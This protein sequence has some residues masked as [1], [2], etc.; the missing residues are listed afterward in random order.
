MI[1]KVVDASCRLSEPGIVEAWQ[2]N[3]HE[4]GTR[5]YGN[6][7]MKSGF[8]QLAYY[9]AE[10]AGDAVRNQVGWNRGSIC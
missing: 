1:G 3:V 6:G 10:M 8:R 4:Q 2:D 5:E 7:R 9:R